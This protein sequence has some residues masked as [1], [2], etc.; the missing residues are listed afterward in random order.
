MRAEEWQVLHARYEKYARPIF[1]KGLKQSYANTISI[2]P[3]LNYENY[4]TLIRSS[5]NWQAMNQAYLK[6]YTRIGLVHGNKVGRELN[7][8]QKRYVRDLYESKFLRSIYEWVQTNL[9]RR[10][11]D[12]NEYTI[13]LIQGLVTDSIDRGY[14]VSQ[15]RAYLERS[16]NSPKFTRVR[17]LR[18]ARTETTTAANHAAFEASEESDLVLDKEWISI[19]DD[20]TRP[21][22]KHKG[23]PDHRIQNGKTAAKEENFIM[24]DG[25]RMM[26]P[27]DPK[28]S[29][30]QV[31]NCRCTYSFVPRRDH[32]GMLIFKN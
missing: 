9:G 6:V 25:S 15:M 4:Q 28:G 22:G 20:R 21:E 17:S 14:S 32:N 13:E 30:G 8:E 16:L 7:K 3:L 5:M 11:T 12:V 27:G 31:I 19:I 26:F 18:I 1:N 23:G 24:S 29:A 2:I 10:I